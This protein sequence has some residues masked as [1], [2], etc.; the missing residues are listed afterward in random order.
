[1]EG[2]GEV[3]APPGGRRTPEEDKGGASND[4][5]TTME[6]MEVGGDEMDK[7]GVAEA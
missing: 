5:R 6:R 7:G 4:L 2:V 1:M 3:T